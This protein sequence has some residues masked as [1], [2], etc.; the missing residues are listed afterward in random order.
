MT[1]LMR[2]AP[3]VIA[4]VFLL[5]QI[6]GLAQYI[7]ARM[8]VVDIRSTGYAVGLETA[9]FCAFYWTRQS[10][11]RNDGK[12]DKK[13]VNTRRAALAV[14]IL[15]MLASGTLNTFKM[16]ADY[17]GEKYA[18]DW[19]GALLVGV[20]PTLFAAVLGILQGF[21]DRLPVP[22]AHN[23]PAN[24]QMR[25][26]ALVEKAISLVDARMDAPIAK[27]V[28]PAKPQMRKCKKCGQVIAKGNPGTHA[29]FDCPKR[30]V[31]K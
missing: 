25:V 27:P 26:Y 29:R 14:G 12:Q 20:S 13:D 9:I 11:T 1:K 31:K 22:P 2:K 19:W 3:L 16:L 8:G 24:L 7:A 28:Q 4:A 15:F 17:T 30:K 23:A 10:I 6:T 5:V 18:L 21:V